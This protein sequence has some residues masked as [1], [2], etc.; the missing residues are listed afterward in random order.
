[1]IREQ[2]DGPTGPAAVFCLGDSTIMSDLTANLRTIM[3][4]NGG[5][6]SRTA[7]EWAAWVSES[8]DTVRELVPCWEVR[9]L[10]IERGVW[11]GI[12]QVAA[13]KVS[14][15]PV[16]LVAAA[17]AAV[18]WLTDF[19][20]IDL[21]HP[22]AVAMLAG[23]QAGGLLSQDDADAIDGLRAGTSPRW[24][25]LGLSRQ[26]YQGDFEQAMVS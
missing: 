1:M 20:H 19:E 9:K 16:E 2:P 5:A 17:D 10:A 12:K 6:S 13:G 11:F 4:A 14:A 26:P 8:V 22:S 7:A 15:A 25:S 18:E 3:T 23:L 21:T 24:R